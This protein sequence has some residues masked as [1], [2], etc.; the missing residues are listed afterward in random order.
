MVRKDELIKK[1]FLGPIQQNNFDI[2]L[3]ELERF[4]ILFFNTVSL[5]MYLSYSMEY[6]E[7]WLNKITTVAPC[8]S[9]QTGNSMS[10]PFESTKLC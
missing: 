9:S 4:F 5:C 1:F 8:V 6:N 7:R 2:R 3:K 10:K